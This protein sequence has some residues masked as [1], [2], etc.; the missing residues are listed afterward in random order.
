AVSFSVNGIDGD[1]TAVQVQR[2][3]STGA[4][5]GPR[6]TVNRTWEATQSHPRAVGMSGAGTPFLVTWQSEDQ[7]GDGWGTYLRILKPE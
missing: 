3:S 5:S 7:D 6:V 1:G 4:L 2:L